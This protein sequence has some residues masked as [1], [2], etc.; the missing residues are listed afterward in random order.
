[1]TV[2]SVVSYAELFELLTRGLGKRHCSQMQARKRRHCHF[3]KA[4]LVESYK[5]TAALVKGDV[6][7]PTAQIHRQFVQ[8]RA[9][10]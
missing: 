7:Y 5:H 8:T 9:S 6:A 1:M 10:R 3:R 2:G 4:A